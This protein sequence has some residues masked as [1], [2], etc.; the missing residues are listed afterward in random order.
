MTEYIERHELPQA[1]FA[2]TAAIAR[3]SDMVSRMLSTLDLWYQRAR[4]RRQL[5][6]LDDR[7]LRDIGIDRAEARVE[8]G[9]PFWQS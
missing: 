8:A 7:Q 9:K 4:Q 6:L 3:P 5:G 2:P 1:S